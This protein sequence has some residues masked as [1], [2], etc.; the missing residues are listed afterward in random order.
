MKNMQINNVNLQKANLVSANLSNA[1]I[2]NSAFFGVDIR[3]AN[4]SQVVMRDCSF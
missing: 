4:L 3:D 1:K 2:I